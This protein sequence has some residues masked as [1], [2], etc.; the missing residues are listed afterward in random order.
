[1]QEG[2]D[3]LEIVLTCPLG[4]KC[5][6]VRDN[7]VYR[8]GWFIKL[9]GRDPSTGKEHDEWGCSIAFQSV[10]S[11]EIARTNTGQTRALESFRNEVVKANSNQEAR[12]IAH[13]KQRQIE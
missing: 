8:C 10:L 6:E 11:V 4:S 13:M 7:K 12:E 5:Q 1:M 9:V 2:L 3:D